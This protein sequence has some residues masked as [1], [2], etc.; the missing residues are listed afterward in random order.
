MLHGKTVI[1][2]DGERRLGPECV[3]SARRQC[4]HLVVVART[5][6]HLT[7]SAGEKVR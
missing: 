7:V 4:A 1:A 3:I 5:A 6:R 2:T